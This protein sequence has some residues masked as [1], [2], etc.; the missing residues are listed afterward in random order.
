[1]MK[2]NSLEEAETIVENNKSLSWIGWDIIQLTKSP[3]A[4]MKPEGIFKNGNWYLK[5]QYNL[6][7]SG[8]E[9]PDKFVR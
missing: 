1:M 2:I 3:T 8:W 5:K 4:W 7:T 9:I 6:S